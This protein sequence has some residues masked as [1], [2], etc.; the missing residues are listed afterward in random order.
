MG[1]G[2]SVG[3][4]NAFDICLEG[5][6]FAVN[7]QVM[8]ERQISHSCLLGMDFLKKY[9][10]VIDIPNNKLTLRINDKE[11]AAKLYESSVCYI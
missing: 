4:V 8:T 5:E 2:R 9:K 6:Y 11:V 1:S 10:A 3:N 7:S